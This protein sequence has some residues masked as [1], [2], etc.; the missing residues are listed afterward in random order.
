MNGAKRIKE[1]QQ[2]IATNPIEFA[3]ALMIGADRSKIKKSYAYEQRRLR[4]EENLRRNAIRM[5]ICP[6][7]KGKLIRGARNKNN[8]YKREWFCR[9]CGETHTI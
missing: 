1:T 2:I 3:T 8:D 4:D 5:N 7:C 6:S 9:T